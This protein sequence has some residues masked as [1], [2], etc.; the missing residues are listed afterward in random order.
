[1]LL[2]TTMLMIF[3]TGCQI[4]Y[5][6]K[7]PLPEMVKEAIQEVSQREYKL[8]EYDCSN[9]ATDLTVYLC[10]LGYDA[11]IVRYQPIKNKYLAH[12][13]VELI[14]G[15]FVYYIDPTRSVGRELIKKPKEGIEEIYNMRSFKIM[16]DPAW[17]RV[18]QED[19][20]GHRK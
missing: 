8:H 1:M 11:R 18:V 13:V 3:S 14:F 12:A 5:K 2:I 9:M 19:Y 4:T 7:P 17:V 6:S 20:L 10:T 15:E 16:R